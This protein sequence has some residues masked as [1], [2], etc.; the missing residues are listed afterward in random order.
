[1][2]HRFGSYELQP[3]SDEYVVAVLTRAD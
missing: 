2:Q 1:V 3:P